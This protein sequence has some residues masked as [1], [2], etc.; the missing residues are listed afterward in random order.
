MTIL[1]NAFDSFFLEFL[2]LLYL[3]IQDARF[4]RTPESFLSFCHYNS[5]MGNHVLVQRLNKLA[6][7]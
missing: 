6:S 3:L 5:E 1:D 7:K 4:Y 2:L